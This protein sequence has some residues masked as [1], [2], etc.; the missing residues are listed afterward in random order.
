VSA[1]RLLTL[2]MQAPDKHWQLQVLTGLFDFV[3]KKPA[4]ILY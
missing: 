2:I 1:N 3:K 4:V